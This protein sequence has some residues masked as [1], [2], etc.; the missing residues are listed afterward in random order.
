MLFQVGLNPDSHS[1][2]EKHEALAAERT[3]ESQFWDYWGDLPTPWPSPG[4]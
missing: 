3:Q 4:S 2:D 1:G